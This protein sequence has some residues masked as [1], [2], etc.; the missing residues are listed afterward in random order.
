MYLRL[1]IQIGTGC[2]EFDNRDFNAVTAVLVEREV[3]SCDGYKDMK[4][5]VLVAQREYIQPPQQVTRES[6]NVT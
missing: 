4:I 2:Y 5:E 3:D 6:E 1:R